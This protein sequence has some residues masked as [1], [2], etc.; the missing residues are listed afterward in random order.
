LTT[1]PAPEREQRLD[2]ARWHL[3][4]ARDLTNGITAGAGAGLLAFIFAP[5]V[6]RSAGVALGLTYF[7]V[8]SGLVAEGFV[9][10][11]LLRNQRPQIWRIAVV[12]SGAALIGGGVYIEGFRV[13]PGVWPLHSGSYDW[14]QWVVLSA[15]VALGGLGMRRVNEEVQMELAV[16]LE[17]DSDGRP[18]GGDLEGEG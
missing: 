8:I 5:E 3:S 13:R 9:G 1:E 2:R 12:A 18:L 7:A 15:V 14:W 16:A 6:T 10:R 17:V 4:W 11:S